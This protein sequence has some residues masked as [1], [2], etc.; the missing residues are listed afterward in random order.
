M[1]EA[2]VVVNGISG[3][4]AL[5]PLVPSLKAGKRVALANKESIVCG[6]ALL[7]E[8]LKQYKGEIMPVETASSPPYFSACKTAQRG[9]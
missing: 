2:D 1:A 7:N 6:K 5:A 9:S 3:F 8:I 4:A